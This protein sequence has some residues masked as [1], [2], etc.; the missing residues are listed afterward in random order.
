MSK[1]ASGPQQAAVLHVV[2]AQLGLHDGGITALIGGSA[3]R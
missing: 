2:C 1:C 3:P